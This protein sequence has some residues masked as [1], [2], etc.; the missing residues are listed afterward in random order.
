MGKQITK[1]AFPLLREK[2][3]F[4]WLDFYSVAIMFQICM[5]RIEHVIVECAHYYF[6]H[7]S[8]TMNPILFG[9]LSGSGFFIANSIKLN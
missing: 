2:A 6:L 8:L 9:F 7:Y 4:V 1:K 5:L 3:G